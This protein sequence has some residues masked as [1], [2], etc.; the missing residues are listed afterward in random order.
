MGSFFGNQDDGGVFGAGRNLTQIQRSAE[1]LFE[2]QGQ[3]V[4]AGSQ[5]GREHTV[6]SWSLPNFLPLK[7]L[8]R[9]L[10]IDPQ[11]RQGV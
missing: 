10:F 1:N 5:A 7:E 3:L 4:N 8:A 9:I 11:C 6:R 2:D